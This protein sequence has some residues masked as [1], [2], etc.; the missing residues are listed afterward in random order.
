MSARAR[1]GRAWTLPPDAPG[2]LRDRPPEPAPTGDPEVDRLRRFNAHLVTARRILRAAV[3][4]FRPARVYACFSGGYDSSAAVALTLS[5]LPWGRVHALLGSAVDLEVLHVNTG[6]GSNRTREYVRSL[7]EAS[8]WPYREE[9]TPESYEE[10]VL[11]HGFPGPGKHGQMYQRLK[12]RA[13]R[14]A[15][16]AAKAGRHRNDLVLMVS[17]IRHDE[18]TI[19]AGYQRVVSKVDAQIWLNP[20]YWAD[21]ATFRRLREVYAVPENPVRRILGM[22]GECACGCFASPGELEQWRDADPELASS[23]EDL[24]RRVRASREARGLP[25]WNW[26]QCPP[27]SRAKG[28]EAGVYQPD[29]EDDL[30]MCANCVKIHRTP[31][32]AVGERAL[33]ESEEA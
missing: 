21:A 28:P 2:C 24:Q 15:V 32:S 20:L 6:I 31:V 29:E 33:R 26:D 5:T 22:S 17:G 11:E 12:E 27:R 30:P 16:R 1:S 3:D 23:I 19:R 9:R 14:L 10:Y 13:I 7:A 4:Y 25:Y 18:S 8:G